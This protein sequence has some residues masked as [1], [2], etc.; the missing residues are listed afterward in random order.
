MIA[1]RL[2][3][4]C[5]H[6]VCACLIFWDTPVF[7]HLPSLPS[8]F[9]SMYAFAARMQSDRPPNRVLVV[10]HLQRLGY[11]GIPYIS[12][13]VVAA[14]TSPPVCLPVCDYTLSHHLTTQLGPRHVYRIP[15][16]SFLVFET[17]PAYFYSWHSAESCL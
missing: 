13:I 14:L 5:T 7:M 3:S 9:V 2:R 1:W 4:P 15:Y 16:M 8:I 10:R 11:P 12:R 6:L 17:L